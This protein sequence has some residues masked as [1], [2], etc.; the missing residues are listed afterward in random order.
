MNT[1]QKLAAAAIL[2]S[3]V[4]G[5]LYLKEVLSPSGYVGVSL[6]VAAMLIL[7]LK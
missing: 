3:N 6:A 7:A 5:I 1:F 2:L 4:L